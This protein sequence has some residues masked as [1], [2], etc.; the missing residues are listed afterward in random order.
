MEGEISSNDAILAAQAEGYKY[1][2]IYLNPVAK[3]QQPRFA[4]VLQVQTY[5]NGT[6]ENNMVKYDFVVDGKG[7]LDF[8]FDRRTR[9]MT[10]YLLDDDKKGTVS[11][12]GYNRDFLA[13]HYAS[14][15]FIIPDD[16]IAENVRRR[17]LLIKEAAEKRKPEQPPD[18]ESIDSLIKATEEE[19]LRARERLELLRKQKDRD[20]TRKKTTPSLDPAKRAPMSA[21]KREEF[22]QKMKD[23]RKKASIEKQA[24][25]KTEEKKETVVNA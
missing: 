3:L 12:K 15:Y 22:A 11:A 24:Q 20:N 9:K 13:S 18:Q 16:E 1:I 17:A 14:N 25:P 6:D 21:K 19:E 7:Y 8:Q 2:K 23:A 5:E 4:G 10:A